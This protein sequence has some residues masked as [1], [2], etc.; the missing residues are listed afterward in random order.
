VAEFPTGLTE[1]EGTVWVLAV[2]AYGV[3][4]TLTTYVGLRSGRAAEAGPLAAPLVEG[5]GIFGLVVLKLV[6]LGLFY[7]AWRV[8]RPPA[9]FAVPLA[10]AVV[11][12]GVTAWNLAVVS[13]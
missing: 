7:A 4:D 6:T 8:A 2:L 1:Y 10:V 13:T 5:Y 11:G 12:V 3:G 9:R